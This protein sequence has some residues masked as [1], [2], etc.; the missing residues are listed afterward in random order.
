MAWTWRITARLLGG[1]GLCEW[2]TPHQLPRLRYVL[3]VPIFRCMYLVVYSQN[4]LADES[5]ST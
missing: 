1:L 3:Y 2:D 4:V 5:A